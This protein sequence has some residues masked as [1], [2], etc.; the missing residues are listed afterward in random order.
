MHIIAKGLQPHLQA[1][2]VGLL[3][4]A[5]RHDVDNPAG[6]VA[7]CAAHALNVTNGRGI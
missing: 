3:F 1:L 7:A 4:L 5:L 6:L 2:S